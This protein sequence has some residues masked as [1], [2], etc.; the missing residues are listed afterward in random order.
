MRGLNDEQYRSSGDTEQPESQGPLSVF[1]MDDL[2]DLAALSYSRYRDLAARASLIAAYDRDADR[3][4]RVYRFLSL[5]HAAERQ[6][7]RRQ[8]V[9]RGAD[10]NPGLADHHYLSHPGLHSP[11]TGE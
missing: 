4:R 9:F 1:F 2:G 10:G 8:V 3:S 6:A 7:S 5:D 11:D